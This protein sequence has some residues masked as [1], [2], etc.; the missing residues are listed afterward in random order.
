MHVYV[1]LKFHRCGSDNPPRRGSYGGSRSHFSTA[2]MIST[3][4]TSLVVAVAVYV[5]PVL[6][7]SQ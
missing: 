6:D 7:Y 1:S 2:L 3:I 4:A 5:M